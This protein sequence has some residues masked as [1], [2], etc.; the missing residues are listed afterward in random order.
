V[1]PAAPEPSAFEDDSV[2]RRIA[3]HFQAIGRDEELAGRIYADDAVLVYVQSGEHIA[4]R[5][6][7]VASRQAYPG[8]P[9]AFTVE[10][11]AGSGDHWV[12]ELTLRFDGADPHHVAA[13]LG[14]R[15]GQVV[16][17]RLY[18]AEPWE[19]PAYRRQWVVDPATGR[20]RAG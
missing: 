6:S 19:P 17:E 7:I 16:S 11:I 3:E 2:R 8:R 5:A 18:I 15:E 10:H 20:R 4:G 14:F 12:A 1:R 9:A 13:V